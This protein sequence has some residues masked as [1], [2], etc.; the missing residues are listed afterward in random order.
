MIRHSVSSSFAVMSMLIVNGSSARADVFQTYDLAWSGSSLGNS[1]I[2][3]GTMTLDLTTLINPT[4]PGGLFGTSYYDIVGDITSLTVTVTGSSAGNDTFTLSDLCAC[5]DF[6][7]F[8]YWN[9]NG[10]TVNMHGNVLAQ[11]IA[12]GG[13]FSLFFSPPGPQGSAILTL[14]TNALEG[15][16]MAMTKFGPVPEPA[17]W[18]MMG[19]GFACLGFAAYRTRKADPAVRFV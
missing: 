14:T 13:D 11:L 9:T 2:A 4:V 17:T 1:A 18:V 8:T 16:P 15:D 19:L 12:D 3:S 6:G 7:S 10:D 5:S